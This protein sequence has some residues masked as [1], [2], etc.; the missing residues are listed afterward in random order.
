MRRASVAASRR[1]TAQDLTGRREFQLV[2]RDHETLTRHRV[3]IRRAFTPYECGEGLHRSPNCRARADAALRVHWSGPS[4]KQTSVPTAAKAHT[5]PF[6]EVS[7]SRCAR[8]QRNFCCDAANLMPHRSCGSGRSCAAQRNPREQRPQ[9]G[10]SGHSSAEQFNCSMTME[11]L[12]AAA[13]GVLRRCE[14]HGSGRS[15]AAPD[16]GN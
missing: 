11:K 5:E 14:D 4:P 6:A 13:T 7:N 3:T 12:A 10:L 9:R 2:G 8:S 15:K 16:R 1:A